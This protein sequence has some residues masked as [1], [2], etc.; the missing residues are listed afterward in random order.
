LKQSYERIK[1]YVFR[2]NVEHARIEEMRALF[3]SDDHQQL[4]A[5]M[6]ETA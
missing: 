5:A 6:K 1:R 3:Y 4:L 2:V